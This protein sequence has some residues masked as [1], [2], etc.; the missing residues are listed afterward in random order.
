MAVS[1][2]EL[3]PT[4]AVSPQ[5]APEDLPEIAAR[6]YATIVNNRPDGEGGS[7]QPASRE[8]EE[9]A[10]AVGLHY[11]HLPVVSGAITPEQA[12][13]M[14]KLLAGAPLPVLAFCR[15][16]ARSA[17]LYELAGNAG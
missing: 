6:G 17:Q 11:V 12:Q 8:L 4:F 10:K 2:R 9:A 16:G 7:T 15:S 14:R 3:G 13:A 1:I 5:L